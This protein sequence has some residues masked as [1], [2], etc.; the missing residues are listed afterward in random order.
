[1]SSKFGVDSFSCFLLEYRQ[2][3]TNSQMQL[4]ILFKHILLPVWVISLTD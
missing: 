3:D 2:T 1:M 4:V